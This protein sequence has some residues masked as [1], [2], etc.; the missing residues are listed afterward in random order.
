[1]ATTLY[2]PFTMIVSGPTSSG[3]SV[4]TRRLIKHAQ[5]IIEPAPERI[6]YCYG[7]YQDIF[8][9]MNDIEFHEGVPQLNQFDGK[10]RTLLILDDL[11]H[12]TSKTVS[13]IFTKISHHGNV[14]VVYLTQNIFYANKENRTITLNA[15]YIVLF[16]NVRDKSQI[17]FLARQMYPGK[18]AHMV[19]AYSDA[20]DAPFSYLFID[21]KPRTDEQHRLRACIF[22]DDQLNYVYVPK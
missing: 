11:M 22:P 13:Q 8:T 5:Q 12:E 19:E 6:L 3:K 4:F 20:T 17:A 2:H 14:S 21:L 9:T 7:V 15:Q 16:K 18:A 1:M 10:Q